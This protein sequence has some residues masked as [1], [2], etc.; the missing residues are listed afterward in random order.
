MTDV[1]DA[2]ADNSEAN[3]GEVEQ[4]ANGAYP[5]FPGNPHNHR[6]TVS[7]DGR[8]PMIVVR[9]NTAVELKAAFD[10][11]EAEGVGA[12]IGAFQAGVKAAYNM[13]Q[14]LG[15]T[16]APAAPQAP[17]QAAAQ[18][19]F[20]QQPAQQFPGQPGQAPAPW[21]NAGAPAQPAWGG[22]GGGGQAGASNRAEP[23]PCPPGWY[24]VDN[25]SGP[26]KDA[27]KAMR[28]NGKDYFKGK[29]AWGGK[30]TYWIAPDVAQAIHQQGFL[31]TG[32]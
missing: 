25:G 14:G 27:W 2:T 23:K 3:W 13:A 26:G 16:P 12:V 21:Q 29:I 28:E 17:F 10:E 1:I 22:N 18:Q 11:A 24:K 20:N 9:A 6:F 30:S 4:D 32:A 31:V 19:P 8:G 15:A 5:E 7:I